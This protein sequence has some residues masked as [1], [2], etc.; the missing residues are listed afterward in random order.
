MIL[1]RT[2]AIMLLLVRVTTSSS[3]TNTHNNREFTKGGLVKGGF[4]IRHVFNLHVKHGT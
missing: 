1:I 3:P 4:A 2:I